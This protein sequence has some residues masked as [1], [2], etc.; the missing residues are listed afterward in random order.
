MKT[1]GLLSHR[2]NGLSCAALGALLL[3][4][5]QSASKSSA[6]RPAPAMADPKPAVAPAPGKVALPT[7]RIKAGST[8]GFTDKNGHAWLP[9]QGFTEGATIERPDLNIEGAADRRIYL[10]ERYSMTRFTQA[11]PNGRYVVNLH[12]CETFD[13]ITGPGQRVF[14][15]N[16]AGREFKDFD[17]WAMTG[18]ALR[19]YVESVPVEITNG[20]LEITFTENIEHPQINGIEI[21]PAN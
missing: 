4:G 5:C 13:G 11:L 9:D 1:I 16:V 15:F 10:A 6:T 17:V 12:F 20:K 7:I 3:A 14:S 19:P 2:L 21:L 18:G 8:E